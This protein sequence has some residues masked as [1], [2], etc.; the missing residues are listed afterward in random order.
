[1]II[2]ITVFKKGEGVLRSGLH[3]TSVFPLN[4]QRINIRI[5]NCRGRFSAHLEALEAVKD[6]PVFEGAA[7]D[8]VL[9]VEVQ[10]ESA[11]TVITDRKIANHLQNH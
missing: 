7:A 9:V 4:C 2:W 3:F 11:A 6:V 8:T 1:M 5:R 10:V